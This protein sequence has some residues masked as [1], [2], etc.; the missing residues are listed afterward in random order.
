MQLLEPHG[1]GSLAAFYLD[2]VHAYLDTLCPIRSWKSKVKPAGFFSGHDYTGYFAEVQRAVRQAVGEPEVRLRG[3]ELDCVIVRAT[4][5]EIIDIPVLSRCN[6]AGRDIGGL[7]S[8]FST[9]QSM[10][11][12][13]LLPHR[14]IE[15]CFLSAVQRRNNRKPNA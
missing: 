11:G 12:A 1:P 10:I 2:S 8:A 13:L 3:S 5:A 7:G 15:V 6:G 14:A 9:R 4:I